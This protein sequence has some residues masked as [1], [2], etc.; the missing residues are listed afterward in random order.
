VNEKKYFSLIKGEP[1]KVAPRSKIVPENEFEELLSARE[2]L[3][4]VQA[5]ALEYRK[6][7]TSDCE[8]IKE[9][10]EKEGFA[11]GYEAWVVQIGQLEKEI[12]KVRE[13]MIKLIMPIALK[14]AKK[15][16]A[17]ELDVTPEVIIDIV[18]GTLKAVAQHKK[19]VLY[20]NK[21]DFETIDKNKS[22]LKQIFEQLESLSVRERDDIEPG[23]CIVETEGGII[24]AQLKDRW[25]SLEAAFSAL[26]S[27]LLKGM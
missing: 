21:R 1:I 10:A 7:V 5:D 13:E 23:G 6:K 12:A 15:I 19:I 20:I 8:I 24:N 2:V 9:K 18:K 11:A 27:Q 4:K 17:R 14:A 25:V 16:V 26:G 22:G 3:E